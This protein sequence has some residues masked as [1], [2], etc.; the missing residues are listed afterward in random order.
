MTAS[1]LSVVVVKS[2]LR[3]D[4]PWLRAIVLSPSVHRFL[5]TVALGARDFRP[6]AA[7]MVKPAN[8]VL[9][10][11]AA[12]PYPGLDHDRFSGTAIT[13]VSTVSYVTHTASLQ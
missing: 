4:N 1:A 5:T 3:L 9:M 12:D 7:L 13:L 6:L 8:S 10:S 11:F 2:N